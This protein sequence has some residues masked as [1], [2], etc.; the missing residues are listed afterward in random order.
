MT[1]PTTLLDAGV[2]EDKDVTKRLH[3]LIK[4]VQNRLDLFKPNTVISAF[5]EWLNDATKQNMQLSRSSMEQFLVLYSTVAPHMASEL[6]ELL[7]QKQLTDC[8]WPTYDESLLG[9]DS[10]VIAIQVNG[11][12]RG[13]I[14]VDFDMP[15]SAIE[16]LAHEHVVKWLEGKEIIKIIYVKHKMISFVIQ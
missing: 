1:H 16:Q 12:M 6:L 14:Q 11:K 8:S 4:I 10:M 5:M 3:Q 15:Q 7:L 13:T 9:Q 2:L